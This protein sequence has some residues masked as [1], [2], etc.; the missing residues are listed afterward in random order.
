MK[1]NK[2]FL[3]LI[4]VVILLPLLSLSCLTTPA[5]QPAAV[6]TS[7]D[8]IIHQSNLTDYATKADLNDKASAGSVNALE[9][10]MAQAEGKIN[11]FQSGT[12]LTQAQVDAAVA[13]A[14]TT[15]KN[16]QSWI[17]GTTYTTPAGTIAGEYGELIDSDGDLELWLDKISGIAT[18][19]LRTTQANDQMARFDFVVVNKDTSD[20]HDFKI[21]LM[22]YPS[23]SVTLDMD[24]GTV[25][26]ADL[27]ITHYSASGGLT[28]TVSRDQTTVPN[29][30]PL[31]LYQNNT[32]R[33]LKSDAEDYTLWLYINQD[34][35]PTG[36]D[37]SWT[38][39]IDDRD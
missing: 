30:N 15:L 20:A 3:L 14:I 8:P 18:D 25:P 31:S 11:A 27:D 10:R 13:A 1:R 17:T 26:P 29:T 22:F 33:I 7:N 5:T 9:T 32:G 36:V 6:A 34:S 37:W 16:D 35:S 12:G 39:T 38:I 23:T 28:Y 19:E 21:N 24:A 2:R 4:A